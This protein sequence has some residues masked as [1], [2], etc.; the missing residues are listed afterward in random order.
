[1]QSCLGRR[2]GIVAPQAAF[3]GSN[4]SGTFQVSE[5]SRCRW[6]QNAENVNDVTDAQFALP[7]QMQDSEPVAVR[8]RPEQHINI[9]SLS[10]NHIR[11]GEY[12]LFGFF[13]QVKTKHGVA[14]T[15]IHS[16]ADK[17]RMGRWNCY[18]SCIASVAWLQHHAKPWACHHESMLCRVRSM[19]ATDFNLS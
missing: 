14:G 3:P 17:R 6:L 15:Q 9:N 13:G 4:K 12:R 5:M 8:Q 16:R 11:I 10:L 1:M 7:Q 18:T 2:Q 19:T